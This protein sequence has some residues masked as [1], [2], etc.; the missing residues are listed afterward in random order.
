MAGSVL[1]VLFV[2]TVAAAN[3]SVGFAAAVYLGVGPPQWR[4]FQPLQ[5]NKLASA[6]DSAET[7]DDLP[8]ATSEEP[9]VGELAATTKSEESD[10]EAPEALPDEHPLS[11]VLEQL[12]R[13]FDRFESELAEWDRRRRADVLDGDGLTNSAIDLNSLAS[14]YLEQFQTALDPLAYLRTQDAAVLAAREETTAC[15]TDASAQ[16]QAV[17]AELG[18]LQF[19]GDDAT[20]G[21]EKLNVALTQVLAMLH[22]ARNRLEEPVVKLL[23]SAVHEP[24]LAATLRENATASLLGRLCFEHLWHAHTEQCSAGE[25]GWALMLDVDG[26]QTLNASHGPLIACRALLAIWEVAGEVLPLGASLARVQGQQFALLLTDPSLE[27]ATEM[28]ERLRQEIAHTRLMALDTELQL[29]VSAAVVRLADADTSHQ[30]LQRLRAAISAAKAHGRNCTF[31]D[32]DAT[33]TLVSPLP[34]HCEA[35]V[36]PL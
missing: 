28:A 19:H 25:L 24:A 33:P 36:L 29:T 34:L 22:A 20:A 14:G 30:L 23:G 31:V 7:S 2:F 16:L 3:L 18:S 6:P 26:L 21:A 10:V 1:L 13:S 35:R 5:K 12:G 11:Q 15:A 4:R 32:D 8:E 27:K 17:C 9:V